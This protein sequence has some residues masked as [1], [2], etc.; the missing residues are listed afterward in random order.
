[1]VGLLTVDIVAPIPSS[2]VAALA[3]TVFGPL[4]GS[5]IVFVGLSL[6]CVVGY[7]IGRL[8]RTRLDATGTRRRAYVAATAIHSRGS[9]VAV[10]VARPV[11]L[12]AEATVVVAGLAGM[13][14][15][16]F[17]VSCLVANAGVAILF[18]ALPTL[19]A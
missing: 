5:V 11:P 19:I 18:A 6:G 14:R 4:L 7:A 16:R 17:M 10:I 1:V 8:A 9:A 12:L 2:L 13:H 3:G 15:A